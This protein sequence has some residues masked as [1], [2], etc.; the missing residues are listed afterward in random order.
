M[1]AQGEQQV[2]HEARGTFHQGYGRGFKASKVKATGERGWIV[3]FY[4]T[5]EYWIMPCR[6]YWANNVRIE[7]GESIQAICTV[8][9]RILSQSSR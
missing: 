1:G 8:P 3:H 7:R 2:G 5:L 4:G 9:L 6:G